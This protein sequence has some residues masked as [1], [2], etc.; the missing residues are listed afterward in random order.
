MARLVVLGG[1]VAGHTAATFA[2]KWLGSEHEVVVVT[3]NA[4][5]NW[6][7][8]NIWVG[9]GEMS[10]EDVTFDLAPVYQKAGINYKQ[11]KAVSINPEGKEGSDKPFVTVEF[12][13]QGKVGET[14]EVQYDYLINATG[15]KLNFAATPGLGDANG[16]GEFTVS[17]CTADHAVH[18]NEEF[19]KTIEKMKKGERQKFL[20]GTGHGMCTCQG[21]AF[22]YIFNIEHELRKAG[23]RDMADLQWIS[24]E[25]FLGDFGVGGLHMKAMG[26][27]VSSRIFAESLFAERNVEWTIGAHVNKVEKGKAHYELLDGSMGEHEFDFAMLIPPFAGVGIK[28]YDKAGEDITATVFAPNGFMKVDANYAAGAYEN[29]KAS[30]WPRTYQNPTYKNMFAAGIAFAPPHG[31]SKPM[32]SPNGTP[33]NPTPPR[34]GM[35]SGIIGKAVAHSVCDLMTKGESAHLHEA[36]MA[37][38]GAAC[39]A[40]AGKGIFTGTAAAMT[41]YPVVPDFEKYPGTGRDT[42]YT[43]G[44]I[45]LAGHWIKHILHHLF[46]YK[47]KLNPGWTLIPE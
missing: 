47:A 12:T 45:G 23:V 13:G 26:F 15:P 39:V 40:S 44:E 1:G 4:K 42:D 17:V 34:T 30:D 28:A 43:F 46:I 31:I 38:M 7:P 10:K 32:S 21:A 14:E 35:P 20:I 41:I 33:I 9:V 16:L 18:A 24:N 5:W 37:E 22:E 6:I 27:A 11:A 8:S 25:S 2:A 29:W 19:Q 36:S 3:P